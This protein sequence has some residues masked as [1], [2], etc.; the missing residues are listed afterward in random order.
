[1]ARNILIEVDE[2][3]DYGSLKRLIPRRPSA[4]DGGVYAA[5]TS[6]GLVKVGCSS[7]P[8]KRL[9]SLNVEHK[10]NTGE[11]MGRAVVTPYCTNYLAMEREAHRQLAEWRFRGER[12]SCTLHEAAEVLRGLPCNRDDLDSRIASSNAFLTGMKQFVCGGYRKPDEKEKDF[13]FHAYRRHMRTRMSPLILSQDL[14]LEQLINFVIDNDLAPESGGAIFC[15]DIGKKLKAFLLSVI[16][17]EYTLGMCEA[18][19]GG[20]MLDACLIKDVV[21]DA[22][23]P[24]ILKQLDAQA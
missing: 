15:E 7:S 17:P 23:S 11:N 13:Q 16:G 21:E 9:M 5:E 12:F 1:M 6:D 20:L 10:V 2:V 4:H 24:E 8:A 14:Y 19:D 18:A 22:I 3:S